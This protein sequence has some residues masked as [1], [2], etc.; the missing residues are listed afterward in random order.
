MY[1]YQLGNWAYSY[2]TRTYEGDQLVETRTPIDRREY[3]VR[4]FKIVE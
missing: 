4:N 1:Y 2:A 3:A